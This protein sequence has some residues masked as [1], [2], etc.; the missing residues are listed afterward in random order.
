[1]SILKK[2]KDFIDRTARKPY[3]ENAIKTYNEP[4]AHYKSFRIIP[5]KLNLTSMVEYFEI[6]CGGGR[7]L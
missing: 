6:E 5:G 4:K 3:G 2:W 1:M 7:L